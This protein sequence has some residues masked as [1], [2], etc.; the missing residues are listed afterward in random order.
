MCITRAA[1]RVLDAAVL[2]PRLHTRVR[3]VH[4]ASQGNDEKLKR[5]GRQFV[6]VGLF[7]A[8]PA[9]KALVVP[10]RCIGYARMWQSRDQRSVAEPLD[11]DTRTLLKRDRWRAQRNTAPSHSC[12][13]SAQM[14]PD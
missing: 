4:N 13:E 10:A 3:L 11:D 12:T 2:R 8:A 5:L 7:V 14:N 9:T 1:A 6:S